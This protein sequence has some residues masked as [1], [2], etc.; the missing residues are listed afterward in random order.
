LN[1]EQLKVKMLL[2]LEKRNDIM[3]F[4]REPIANLMIE[5]VKEQVEAETASKKR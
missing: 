5:A 2:A 3:T 1:Y 4:N